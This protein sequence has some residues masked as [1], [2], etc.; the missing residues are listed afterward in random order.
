M[1]SKMHKQINIQIDENLYDESRE[2]FRRFGLSVRQAIELFL[3]VAKEKNTLPIEIPLSQEQE[4]T[5]ATS[6]GLASLSGTLPTPES[7]IV[8]RLCIKGVISSKTAKQTL[9]RKYQ[10]TK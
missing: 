2:L 3:S 4:N 8:L 5:F 1:S 7:Q 10:E 6:I 9:I